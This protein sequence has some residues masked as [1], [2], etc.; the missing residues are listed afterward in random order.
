[1]CSGGGLFLTGEVVLSAAG[2]D[3]RVREET[4]LMV[5]A[6]G[7]RGDVGLS[8]CGVA[9][10]LAACSRTSGALGRKNK[11]ETKEKKCRK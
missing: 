9:L 3:A 5:G 7:H 10:E 8:T 11:L 6:S 1:L 4:G 2:K